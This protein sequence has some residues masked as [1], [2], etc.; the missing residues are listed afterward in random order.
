VA[1][2]PDM[3]APVGR[4][5]SG[6]GLGWLLVGLFVL[7]GI[8]EHAM[9]AYNNG[10][11]IRDHGLVDPDSY[12]RVMR[13]IALYHGAGWYDTMTMRVGAPEGLSLHW[14]RPVDLLILL[15]ALFAHLFGLSVERGIYWIG[16]A[17]SPICHLLACLAVA[18]AARPL[19][20]SPGH[21]FAALILLTNAAAFGYG[22]FGRADHHTLLLLLTALMFGAA[23]RAA[24]AWQPVAEERRWAAISGLFAGLGIWISP[25]LM[26]PI[27]P[28]VAAIGLFWLDA[29]LDQAK[30][31]GPRRDWA[32]LGIAFALAM[33]AVMLVAIPI[34]QPPAHWL[35]AEYDKVSLPYLVVPLI[36]AAV[37]GI[38]SRVHGGFLSRLIAGV[39][40][41]A[42]G[43]AVLLGLFPDLLFGP[44]GVNQRLKT[45]FLDTV[46]EMQPL[47]PTSFGRLQSF[48]QMLGQSIPSLILLPFAFWIW[49]GP[50]RWAGQMLALSFGFL[51]IAGMMHARLGVEFAPMPAII[52]AGFFSLLDAKLKGRSPL[53]R[54][55]ALV[56]TAVALT[57]APLLVG[58]ALNGSSGGKGD[59][60]TCKVVNLADWLN[61][62]HPGHG[63]ADGGAP[64]V[65]T[66]DYS[67]GPELAFRTD[68]RLVAGPYHRNPQAI[69][70]TI[71]TMTDYT[72]TAAHQILDRR[73]VSLVVRCTD[74]TVTRYYDL[75]HLM[76][77]DRLGG[78]GSLPNWLTQLTL[79][80]ALGKHFRVYEVKGR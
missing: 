15:P 50:R 73:Q 24:I 48:L 22:V 66:D 19:W 63:T 16:A 53:L 18:W 57:C 33:A 23:L 8:T 1:M 78:Q 21:R 29:P 70:D 49:R 52:C 31:G 74:V 12:M 13:I 14:T 72:E 76:V 77:Y 71:D 47:W 40:L 45:D 36:W 7:L 27:T 59:A 41:G 37:F 3:P 58:L 67:Y 61:A 2:T 65:M 9:F 60:G 43:L 17:F 5:N 26:V 10:E 34:E 54:T 69:F 28:I 35:T 30:N 20:P 42:A 25:E 64:I 79:P 62:H 44:L 32:A 11:V 4:A 46:R 38:A 56:L 80:E 55:P 68:Y 6:A 75:L 39:L 51:L